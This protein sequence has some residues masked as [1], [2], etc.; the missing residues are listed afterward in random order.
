MKRY[1][2]AYFKEDGTGFCKSTTEPWLFGLYDDPKYAVQDIETLK[3]Y[4]YKNVE[5]IP[6]KKEYM[7]ESQFALDRL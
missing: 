6:Y 7:Y 3:S 2:I 1:T 4:G 5:L